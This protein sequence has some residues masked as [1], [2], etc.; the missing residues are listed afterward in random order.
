M[1]INQ[2]FTNIIK[3]LQINL[4]RSK[5]ATSQ[6]IKF[7]EEK[8]IDIVLAQEPYCIKQKVCG[9]PLNYKVI[10]AQDY[11]QPQCAKVIANKAIQAINISSYTCKY[12]SFANIQLKNKY[13]LLL[14]VF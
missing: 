12:A 2:N 14:S 11:H 5:S 7:I 13:I 6:L 4:Q 1:D 8:H 10:Y 3:C 9:F